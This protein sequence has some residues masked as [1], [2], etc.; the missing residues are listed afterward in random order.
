MSGRKETIMFKTYKEAYEYFY[1]K[2]NHYW[3]LGL[4][5]IRNFLKYFGSPENKINIIQVA[6]TNGKGSVSA[7]M[8]NILIKSGFRTGRY[9]SP[10][11]FEERENITVNNIKMSEEEFTEIVNYMYDAMESSEREKKLPTVFELETAMAVIYFY[12]AKCDIVILE[13]G[14]GGMTDATN[15]SEKNLI[16]VI[17]SVSYDHMKYLGNTIG[18]IAKI[19]SGIIKK[20]SCVVLGVNNNTACQIISTRAKEENAVLK[21][22]R[23]KNIIIHESSVKGQIFSYGRFHSLCI[24]QAG[25]YQAENSAAAIEAVLMLKEICEK[26]NDRLLREKGSGICEEALRAGLMETVWH[27]RFETISEKPLIIA[28]GA[29]NPDASKRL[30]ESIEDC[31]KDYNIV[32]IMGVFKDKDYKA[33]IKEMVPYIYRTVTVTVPDKRAL[34]AEDIKAA[35]LETAGKV[36]YESK[37]DMEKYKIKAAQNYSEAIKSAEEM[38][39]EYSMENGRE[40]AIIAF[41]S[42]SYLKYIKK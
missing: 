30:K 23:K 24:R 14:L 9:N 32:C 34:P 17:T 11:V 35:I 37:E 16:S 2:K 19:K 42:L 41:G 26:G 22:V 1:G 28:D 27:G 40:T 20:N 21:K 15:V 29:H 13:A 3:D 5:N 4:D 18:E 33:I 7:F 36:N 6:G 10:A 25:K 31:L 8:S 39:K 12:K 38:A